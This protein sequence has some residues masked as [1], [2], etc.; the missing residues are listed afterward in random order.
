VPPSP[1]LLWIPG[2]CITFYISKLKLFYHV[3]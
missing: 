2:T 1:P 3:K